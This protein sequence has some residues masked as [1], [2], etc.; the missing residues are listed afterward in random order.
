MKFG[1][2]IFRHLVECE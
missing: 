2:E 1:D